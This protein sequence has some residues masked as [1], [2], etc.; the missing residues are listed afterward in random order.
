MNAEG[1]RQLGLVVRSHQ[2]Q[3]EVFLDSR[4]VPRIQLQNL[5][6]SAT[7]KLEEPERH[8]LQ[9]RRCLIMRF[10]AREIAHISVNFPA[11]IQQS[12]ASQTDRN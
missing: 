12:S 7:M 6:R 10:A 8:V 2:R 1:M 11:Q 4:N 9:H 3:Q 5:S